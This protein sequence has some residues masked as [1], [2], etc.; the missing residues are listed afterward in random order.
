MAMTG[1]EIMISKFIKMLGLDPDLIMQKVDE[2]KKSVS[3]ASGDIAAIRRDQLLIMEKL[4]IAHDGT[5]R[6]PVAGDIAG[7]DESGHGLNGHAVGGSGRRPVS[8]PN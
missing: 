5:E 7:P 4:G 2:I 6:Q 8:K 1:T 3:N